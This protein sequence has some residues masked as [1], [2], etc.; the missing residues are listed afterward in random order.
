MGASLCSGIGGAAGHA[1]VDGLHFAYRPL[2]GNAAQLRTWRPA[3]LDSGAIV[4]F[5][6]YIDNPAELAGELGANPGDL[7]GLY[8]SEAGDAPTDDA[9]E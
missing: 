1:E 3:R 5:H 7:A 9:T 4:A 8:A 2:T 6:G